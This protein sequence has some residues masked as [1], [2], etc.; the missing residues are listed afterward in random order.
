[1]ALSYFGHHAPVYR[2]AEP[3]VKDMEQE[4]NSIESWHLRA[5]S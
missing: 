3:N 1:M 5:V 4:E 2:S